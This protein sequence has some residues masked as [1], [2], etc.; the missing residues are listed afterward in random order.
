MIGQLARHSALNLW[1]VNR[2][3]CVHSRH[4]TLTHQPQS[5]VTLFSF[6]CFL[7]AGSMNTHWYVHKGYKGNNGEYI[8]SI[9]V[10]VKASC[11]LS[12]VKEAGVVT[13]SVPPPPYQPFLPKLT[14]Y[15]H[16]F[17]EGFLNDHHSHGPASSLFHC[18]PSPPYPPF[19]PPP[20]IKTSSIV[21]LH[22][23]RFA[24]TT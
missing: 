15:F 6:R 20:P 13:P 3:Y 8:S 1:C 18:Y 7:E 19:L 10:I 14:P 4:R 2:A 24:V 16:M 21:H 9:F 22:A 23:V 5:H 12:K 17:L 11:V